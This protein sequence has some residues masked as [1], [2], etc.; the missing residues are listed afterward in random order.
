MSKVIVVYIVHGFFIYSRFIWLDLRKCQNFRKFLLFLP[1]WKNEKYRCIWQEDE[2]MVK[3]TMVSKSI[4]TEN[5]TWTLFASNPWGGVMFTWNIKVG[6]LLKIYSCG[7]HMWS[8]L[9][10]PMPFQI[11]NWRC[12]V[13]CFVLHDDTTRNIFCNASFLFLSFIYVLPILISYA[14]DFR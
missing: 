9:L 14:L 12:F 4:K 5:Q 6:W 8:V 1:K 11:M 7:P 3:A 2:W 10:L 13:F